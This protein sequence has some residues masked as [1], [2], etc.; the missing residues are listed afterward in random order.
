M[1]CF[2]LK[3]CSEKRQILKTV[4]LYKGIMNYKFKFLEHKQIKLNLKS[5]KAE[6]VLCT[7]VFTF[8]YESSKDECH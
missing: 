8:L 6:F 7:S 4:S 1:R 5:L 3:P 2:I